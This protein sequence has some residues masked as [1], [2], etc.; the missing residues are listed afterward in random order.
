MTSTIEAGRD[1]PSD[2]GWIFGAAWLV[3]LVFPV[4]VIVEDATSVATR[5]AAL[6][7]LAAYAAV[8]TAGLFLLR[9]IAEDSARINILVTTL[10]ALIV[11]VAATAGIGAALAMLPFVTCY[12]IFAWPLGRSL[13]LVAVA[14]AAIIGA[15][16][17]IDG[18]SLGAYWQILLFTAPAVVISLMWRTLLLTEDDRRHLEQEVA[19]LG[20]RDRIAREVHDIL[21]HGLTV[22]AVKAELASRLIDADPCR[23]Q[24]EIEA[25]HDLSRTALAEVRAAVSGLRTRNLPEALDAAKQALG[26]AGIALRTEISASPDNAATAAAFASAVREGTTNIIRHST[27]RACRIHID[28]GRV[29]ITNDG[30]P[31]GPPSAARRG[32]GLRGLAERA[33]AA[34]GTVSA[35][36][37]GSGEF[38]LE[39][40]I[41]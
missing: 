14:S 29:R 16:T 6:V 13:A 41:P 4:M 31:A 38:T 21:G 33:A 10:I 23:A 35:G 12:V 34:G 7:L 30:A 9:D 15:P 28:R 11:A 20:E 3:F 27:A 32:N 8:Y 22:I 5:A 26:T 24:V 36:T 2:H 18:T 17:L 1:E 39:V 40:Q 19:R 25:V 37:T